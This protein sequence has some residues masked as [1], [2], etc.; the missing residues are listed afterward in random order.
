MALGCWGPAAS[1]PDQEPRGKRKPVAA[2]THAQSYFLGRL[3]GKAERSIS[4]SMAVPQSSAVTAPGLTAQ[5]CASGDSES[6]LA[7]TISHNLAES[8][9]SPFLD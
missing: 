3:E 1:C 8:K 6:L 2:V 5:R 7:V 9:K 4:C